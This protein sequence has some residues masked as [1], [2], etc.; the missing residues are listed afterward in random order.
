MNN[1][2]SDSDSSGSLNPL[3]YPKINLFGADLSGKNLSNVEFPS[4]NLCYSN[5]SGTNLKNANLRNANLAFT[6]LRYAWLCGANLTGVHLNQTDFRGAIYDSQSQ[7]D[8]DPKMAGM[9][10]VSQLFP[11]L[12][13]IQKRELVLI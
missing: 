12:V 2:N 11:C 9:I 13:S 7:F 3:F 4:A 6:N 1:D 8:F 5:L 10:E